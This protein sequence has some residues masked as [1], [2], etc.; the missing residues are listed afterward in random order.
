ML[1]TFFSI[2]T[3]TLWLYLLRHAGADPGHKR[4]LGAGLNAR[5]PSRLFGYSTPL[6]TLTTKSCTLVTMVRTDRLPRSRSLFT[7]NS[8]TSTE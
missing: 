8:D 1:T 5:L 7:A 6:Q 2:L 3:I 4:G